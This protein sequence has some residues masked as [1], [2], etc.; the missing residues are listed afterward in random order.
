MQWGEGRGEG[1]VAHNL[2]QAEIGHLHATP[3]VQQDVL[4]LDVAMDD[5]LVVGE[6]GRIANVRHD[7]Q[8]LARRNAA[9]RQKLPQVHAIHIFHQEEIQPVRA[10]EVVNGRAFL[11]AFQQVTL[12][13]GIII[14]AGIHDSGLSPTSTKVRAPNDSGRRPRYGR[15]AG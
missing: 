6:L 8:R 3:A 4:R 2:R 5:A 11:G 15:R 13:G 9:A 1:F 14:E 10:A 7:D 12:L